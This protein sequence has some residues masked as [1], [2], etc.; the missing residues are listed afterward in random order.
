MS[1][2]PASR[3][4]LVGAGILIATFVAGGLAGAALQ[5]FVLA[6][7]PPAREARHDGNRDRDRRSRPPIWEGLG[8]TPEQQVRI[9]AVL[10]KRNQQVRVLWSEHEPRLRA[11]Y[12]STRAEIHSILTPEQRQELERRREERRRRDREQDQQQSRGG[13]SGKDRRP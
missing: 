12:D 11:V 10:E 3:L 2:A 9:D 7:E 13:E 1:A 8:V 4:R 5:Q 6:D